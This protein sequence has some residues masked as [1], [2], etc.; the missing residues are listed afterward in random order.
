MLCSTLL[1]F[2]LHPSQWMLTFRAKVWYMSGSVPSSAAAMDV[3]I[4]ERGQEEERVV[5]VC[6]FAY[7]CCKCVETWRSEEGLEGLLQ[8]AKGGRGAE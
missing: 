2:F 1:T 4:M 8:E 3:R 6:E 7:C 5:Y